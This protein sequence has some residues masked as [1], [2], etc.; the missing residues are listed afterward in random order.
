MVM[1]LYNKKRYLCIHFQ[2]NV[3]AENSLGENRTVC[4]VIQ[5]LEMEIDD[6]EINYRNDIDE[7]MRRV[8]NSAFI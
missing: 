6:V 2:V 3:R 1:E 5:S 4:D 7:I 8:S